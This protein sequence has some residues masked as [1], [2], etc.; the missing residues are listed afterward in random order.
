MRSCP[1]YQET[2]WLDVYGELAADERPPWERHLA[3]C[4]SCRLERQ[5]LLQMLDIT[6]KVMSSPT[7]SPEESSA[8]KASISRAL[9][10]NVDQE[11]SRKPFFGIQA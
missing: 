7:L 2:L 1:E 11:W 6:K 4:D 9:R 3:L 5:R 8:L 10:R